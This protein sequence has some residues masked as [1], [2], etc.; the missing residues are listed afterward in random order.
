MS[1]NGSMDTSTYKTGLEFD[2]NGPA[3]RQGSLAP[4][5]QK[6]VAWASMGNSE[7][8][9][10]SIKGYGRRQGVVETDQSSQVAT[11]HSLDNLALMGLPWDD[12]Y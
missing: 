6:Y 8:C 10:G 11:C 1:E 7:L 4:L 12:R 5:C 2:G 3:K 9:T